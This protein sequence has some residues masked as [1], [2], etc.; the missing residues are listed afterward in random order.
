L[1]T[2][3]RHG[4]PVEDALA[5]ANKRFR[6]T[7]GSDGGWAYIPARG[8]AASST[9]SMTCA[10]L[11]ALAMA[12]G[13]GAEAARSDPK[14]PK[15]ADLGKDLAIRS[16]LVALGSVVGTSSVG[17]GQPIR[18]GYYFLWSL[19]RVGVAYNLNAIAAKDWYTW[20]SDILLAN[21]RDDG[22]WR[23]EEA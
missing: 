19:E 14:A 6:D 8:G 15:P 3:R 11:L 12:H 1:W 7:Q 16:A 5:R 9:A 4:V 21:Q 22:S 13:T 2:A 18:K 17:K 23:G 10:G 20:G